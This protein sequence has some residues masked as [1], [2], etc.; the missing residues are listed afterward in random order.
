MFRFA[1]LLI[2]NALLAAAIG[3]QPSADWR[4]DRD[5]PDRHKIIG[6]RYAEPEEFPFV[7]YIDVE[8]GFCSGST[9]APNWILTAA[10]CVVN[11]DG[12][13]AAQ[14]RIKVERGYPSDFEVRRE[15]RQSGSS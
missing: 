9:V 12:S 6:G 8:N 7:T 15:D 5:H 10:H 2:C 13:I 1:A 4:I 14:N 11:S 3:A